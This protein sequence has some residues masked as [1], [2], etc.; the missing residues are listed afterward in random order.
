MRPCSSSLP[1]AFVAP[2]R[3]SVSYNLPNSHKTP[4]LPIQINQAGSQIPIS[5]SAKYLSPKS[6]TPHNEFPIKSLP[7]NFTEHSILNTQATDTASQ[8]RISSTDKIPENLEEVKKKI[9]YSIKREDMP[10]KKKRKFSVKKVDPIEAVRE[11]IQ[12]KSFTTIARLPKNEMR[13]TENSK[14]EMR[15]GKEEMA[16]YS[17]VCSPIRKFNSFVEGTPVV[18]GE[19]IQN[20]K[21]REIKCCNCSKSHCVKLYC[22]CFSANRFCKGCNCKECFNIES[23]KTIRNYAMNTVT[24]RN[25]Y[26]FLPKIA[27]LPVI[28][29]I[30]LSIFR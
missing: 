10:P 3:P 26:A 29:Y 18:I 7:S 12:N 2:S 24:E 5:E 21:V 23:K 1:S 17:Q 30:V 20:I 22:E 16:P 8:K 15:E 13:N 4:D 11:N 9:E 27:Q 28:S 25:P 14:I 19:V 6:A